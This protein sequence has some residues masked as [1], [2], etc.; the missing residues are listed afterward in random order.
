MM[1]HIQVYIASSCPMC[2]YSRHLAADIAERCPQVEIDAIDIVEAE[3]ELPDSVFA[4]PIWLWD[5]KLFSLGNPDPAQI[6]RRLTEI[7]SHT[8]HIAQGKKSWTR[9]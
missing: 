9:R 1:T 4:T 7:G 8:H 2:V 5:G 6:W 3:Q